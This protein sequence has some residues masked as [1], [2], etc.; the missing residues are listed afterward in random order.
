M[1]KRTYVRTL[2]KL[3]RCHPY[4]NQLAWRM[5]DYYVKKLLLENHYVSVI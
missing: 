1:G 5:I 4:F 3:Q 2:L